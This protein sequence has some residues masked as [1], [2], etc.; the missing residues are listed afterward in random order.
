MFSCGGPKIKKVDNE[1]KLFDEIRSVKDL[2]L[3]MDLNEF[4]FDFDFFNGEWVG[5]NK[6]N[7][8]I[9]FFIR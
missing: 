5:K 6:F 1:Q 8:I 7:L 2:K 4:K 9:K 3:K